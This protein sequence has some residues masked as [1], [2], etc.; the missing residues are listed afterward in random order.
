MVITIM[1]TD[2]GNCYENRKNVQEV[3]KQYS[4]CLSYL[5]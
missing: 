3:S 2:T 5:L 1:S 4:P